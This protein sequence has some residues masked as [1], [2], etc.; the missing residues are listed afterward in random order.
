MSDQVATNTSNDKGPGVNGEGAGVNL[1]NIHATNNIKL[2]S[3]GNIRSNNAHAIGSISIVGD[4]VQLAGRHMAD[5]IQNEG[6]DI[7]LV[8][9][10]NTLDNQG[11]IFAESLDFNGEK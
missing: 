6:N 1:N 8:V 5:K 2:T 9:R 7:P 10:A 3:Q 4:E 11:Q